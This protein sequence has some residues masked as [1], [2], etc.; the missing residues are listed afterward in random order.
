MDATVCVEC[1]LNLAANLKLIKLRNII[2]HPTQS[3][4]KKNK[5]PKLVQRIEKS[6]NQNT[7]STHFLPFFI[8]VHISLLL[9]KT[10]LSPGVRKWQRGKGDRKKTITKAPICRE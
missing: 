8:K 1:L 5:K 6:L 7:K 4:K 10:V 9:F 3:Q 2:N